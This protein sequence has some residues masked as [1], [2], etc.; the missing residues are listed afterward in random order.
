MRLFVG[1]RQPWTTCGRRLSLGFLSLVSLVVLQLLPLCPLLD[2][3]RPC[4]SSLDP[5]YTEYPFLKFAPTQSHLSDLLEASSA[6]P[7]RHDI[8]RHV[9]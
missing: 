4:L 8:C 6:P 2:V 5:P 9:P 3:L 7:E 1:L